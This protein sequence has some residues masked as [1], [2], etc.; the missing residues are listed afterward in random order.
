MK[1]IGGYLGLESLVNRELYKDLVAVNNARNALLYIMKAKNIKKLYIPY[2]LCDSVSGVCEREGYSYEQ[3]SVDEKFQPIFDKVLDE[4]EY[5]YVVNYYGQLDNARIIEL[6]EKHGNIICDN[7][8]AFFQPP[9]EGID[10][11]Y[12]CRKFFGV[13]DGGY[14][15]TD[16]PLDEHLDEDS[17]KDRMTHILG[18]F[19]C[20]RGSDYYADFKQNDCLFDTLELRTMSRITHNIMGAIDYEAVKDARSRNFNALNEL[21]GQKNLLKLKSVD[22]P[23]AYPFYCENGA[24]V[25]KKLIAQKIFV[26]TLWPNAIECEDEL[27]RR[28]SENILPLPC[29]QRYDDTDMTRIAKEVL[30]CIRTAGTSV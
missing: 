16:K 27:A 10:T 18:R 21:L 6:K 1:E 15:Y 28:Y 24:E 22:G 14:L 8:Q 11:V 30:K 12:S 2:Y 23:Y 4:N 20:G 13:P 26:P 3:Y 19:E 7:V 17:S 29:D 5:L 9:V 25:R